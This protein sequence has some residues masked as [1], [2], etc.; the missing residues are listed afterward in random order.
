MERRSYYRSDLQPIGCFILA[1]P[2]L[3]I[4]VFLFMYSGINAFN[5]FKNLPDKP[6]H[7]T[8]AKSPSL[9]ADKGEAW[10]IIDDLVWDCNHIFQE[11]Q[12]IR[13]YRGR[14]TIIT[15]MHIP[16]TNKQHNIFGETRL[17][18]NL[19]YV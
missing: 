1:L 12:V 5:E 15:I 6:Q 16:F 11:T 13:S 2:F 19:T 4:P 14:D 17:T 7:T 9:L 3:I 10:V 18:E 8:L